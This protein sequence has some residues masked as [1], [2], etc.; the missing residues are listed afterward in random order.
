MAQVTIDVGTL[1][2]CQRFILDVAV[3]FRSFEHYELFDFDPAANRARQ[4]GCLSANC[5][6]DGAGFALNQA[7]ARDV[8]LYPTINMK[9]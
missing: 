3:D 4:P 1:L 7:R 5:A 8:A 6:M 9:F 2:D